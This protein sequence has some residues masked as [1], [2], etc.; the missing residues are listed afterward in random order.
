MPTNR[1]TTIP[2]NSRPI[3]AFFDDDPKLLNCE[4]AQPSALWRLAKRKP[5]QRS[6]TLSLGCLGRGPPPPS[7]RPQH[8]SGRGPGDQF[9]VGFSTLGRRPDWCWCRPD[10]S[11]CRSWGPAQAGDLQGVR[12]PAGR[13]GARDSLDTKQ[14]GQSLDQE[15]SWKFHSQTQPSQVLLRGSSDEFPDTGRQSNENRGET[16]GRA[17]NLPSA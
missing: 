8:Q 3:S 2:N 6:P 13:R 14:G 4:I 11:W 12:P 1:H 9:V 16:K 7:C 15:A 10:W 5:L 17:G